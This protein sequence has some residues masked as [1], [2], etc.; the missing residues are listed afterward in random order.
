MPVSS[1]SE[2]TTQHQYS[3]FESIADMNIN[4]LINSLPHWLKYST[5]GLLPCSKSQTLAN[6][7]EVKVVANK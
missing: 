3:L 4:T 5:T 1:H 7:Q 2:G 6:P